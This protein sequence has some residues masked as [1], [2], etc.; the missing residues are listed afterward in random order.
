MEDDTIYTGEFVVDGRWR[1]DGYVD[2]GSKEHR[3]IFLEYNGCYWHACERCGGRGGGD[4]PRLLTAE[5]KERF[6][7]ERDQEKLR[8]LKQ[9][10]RVII[11]RECEVSVVVQFI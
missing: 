8:R 3:P 9:L 11:R 2:F 7:R 1:V 10:G 6:R 4:E 5:E